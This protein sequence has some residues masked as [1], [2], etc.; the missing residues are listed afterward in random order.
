M[1]FAKIPRHKNKSSNLA[2]ESGIGIERPMLFQ[3]TEVGSMSPLWPYVL[4][5]HINPTT[6]Q[7]QFAK[8]K[9]VVMTR[10]GFVEFIWPDDIDSLSADGTTGAFIGPDSGLT[11]D[12]SDPEYRTK[13]GG[14]LRDFRGRR[15]TLAWERHTDLLELF[16][17]NGQIF[18]GAGMPV[19]RSQIMCICDRGIYFGWFSTFEE[20]ESGDT[21]FQF[22]L[23]WEFKVSQTVYNLPWALG[24]DVDMDSDI[25]SDIENMNA[26]RS[27]TNV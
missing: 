9:S 21:P 6:L 2:V 13:S 27:R 14:V 11:A 7:E 8:N 20:I 23:S 19:L 16:R 18:N 25:L 15:G 1:P 17:S 26:H 3:V 10:G 5:L 24:V 12:S 22:K 4:A